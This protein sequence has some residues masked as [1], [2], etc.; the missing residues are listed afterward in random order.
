MALI[1]LID[2][3]KKF[4]TKTVLEN[5]NFSANL[6][7]KIAIIGKNGE[8]KSSFLKAL[9]GTLKLDSGRVIKQNNTSIGMLSQQ[10]SFESALSV[11][12]AIKKE[13]EE[14]YKVLKEF[15]SYNEKLALDPENKEYL[16]KVDELSLFIDSKDAWNLDQKIQRILEE[17]KLLEYKD[18]TLCSLSGGEIRRVGLCTLLLKNP[19][20]L[21]LDEPT[22]HLD[23]YMSSFLEERLK[24]SKMCVIFISHDRYF[25]DAIAQKC[26][27]IEAGKLSV[28]E[29]GYTQYLEKKRAIL[30]SLAKSHETL[31]KQLKS[32][33]EWL[34]RG[35]KARLKRNEGRKERIFKMRE[36][37]KKNPGA[38]KRLQLEIKR[39]SK[40]FNQT[41]SQNRKKMLFELKNISKSIAGKTLF[42]DFNARIL[43]GERIAIVGKNGCGKST[44][45]KILLDQIPLDS[46]EIKRGEVKIGYFDQS[47][48]LLNTDKKL[49]EIF[50]PNGGDHIQ[51]R[52]KNMHV[53]GYLKQFLF[54]KE[55]LEQSVSVLSGGEKNRVALALLFTKEY[56][57]LV[58]DEPTNDLD[59]AT[60]NILE[61]YLLSFEGAILLVSHDRYFVDKIATKLYAFE[62]NANIN[63]EVLSYSEYLENEKEYKDFEEFSKSLETNTTTSVKT[64][65]K[66][67][68]K[69]SYKENEILN[70]YPDKIHKLEEEIKEIKNALSNPAIY[71]ELGI[72]TLYE[73]LNSLESELSVLEEAYFEVLEKSE[74][75]D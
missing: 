40:N 5:A 55:F 22:N 71:Q 45:L 64:K 9:M 73:K 30:A 58:L 42:K 70:S 43:Q 56:D 33:E 37:A 28:F 17:F 48:S 52:G 12:E 41:Q 3:N 29:G 1:D 39:A 61:E 66:S 15:E 63:I 65:E 38:I 44:F 6:G 72:N 35:V 54:P 74:N 14:I 46:G 59:I 51:V 13:L 47:R 34:R 19:D 27:E 67:S 18:R 10:V 2:A 24:A 75:T 49:L 21:L 23:V 36:E 53:Y 32:E 57:V 7:E 68:K 25:I 16:K 26:I 62:D 50:C 20:I 69:L 31:L 60:I 11:S 8:G 4:N